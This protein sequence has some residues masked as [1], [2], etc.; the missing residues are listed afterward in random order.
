[1]TKM[2]DI[3]PMIDPQ[4]QVDLVASATLWACVSL[5]V[6]WG[7]YFFQAQKF[8]HRQQCY[9]FLVA[10]SWTVMA[11]SVHIVNKTLMTTLSAPSFV[12]SLQMAVA[13]FLM[14]L[15]NF[16]K[17]READYRQV[18]R[19][20]GMPLLFACVLLTTSYAY[21]YATLSLIIIVRNL[22]PL[23]FVPMEYMVQSTGHFV[24]PTVQ[25]CG[26]MTLMVAG[27]AIYCCGCYVSFLGVCF[28]VG[29]FV[30]AVTER[31]AQRYLLLSGGCDLPLS[32]G[33]TLNNVIGLIVPIALAVSTEVH[34]VEVTPDLW[35]YPKTIYLLAFSTLIGLGMS[36]F[37]NKLHNEVSTVSFMAVQIFA[38]F[39]TVVLSFVMFA[40]PAIA[41]LAALGLGMNLGASFWYGCA[42]QPQAKK[43]SES[44]YLRPSQTQE[45]HGQPSM[46]KGRLH[47]DDEH[48]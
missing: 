16:K 1:M 7:L 19:W 3:F 8:V 48:H 25:A 36:F 18:L 11:V 39:A 27:V 15:M 10:A 43:N 42:D 32:V 47:D 21:Q 38:K 35:F 34:V 9:V 33:A 40:D 44:T 31:I 23:V 13:A 28:A 29:T 45:R 5:I 4:S 2:T 6:A 22:A 12:T 46:G 17:L 37:G 20:F 14:V 41:P 30:L 24:R 26:A